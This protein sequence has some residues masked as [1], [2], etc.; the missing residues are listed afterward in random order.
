MVNAFVKSGQQ[1]QQYT[2]KQKKV[3]KKRSLGKKHVPEGSIVST[4]IGN[5]WFKIGF[6]KN[7]KPKKQQL[8]TELCQSTS[9]SHQSVKK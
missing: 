6:L 8:L 2:Y 9:G 5:R 4:F 1:I 7:K 3:G